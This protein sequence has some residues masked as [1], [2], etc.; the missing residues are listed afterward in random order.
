MNFLLLPRRLSII[1]QNFL[2]HS[3]F[4]E[5]EFFKAEI[6]IISRISNLIAF[7]SVPVFNSFHVHE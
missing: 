3:F 2:R 6:F 1:L 7:V 4:G 5:K